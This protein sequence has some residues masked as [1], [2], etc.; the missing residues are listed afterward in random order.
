MM[1]ILDP[2]EVF[3][4]FLLIDFNM[5]VLHFNWSHFNWLLR[6]A[7]KVSFLGFQIIVNSDFFSLLLLF[8]CY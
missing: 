7:D 4:F 8:N 1:K 2:V 6:I 3:H 5:I